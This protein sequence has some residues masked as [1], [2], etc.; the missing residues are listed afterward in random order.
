[1]IA[2]LADDEGERGRGGARPIPVARLP[3]RRGRR[4]PRSDASRGSGGP[5]RSQSAT[6][7]SS[8]P[9][10]AALATFGRLVVL[11]T[12]PLRRCPR[13][14]TARTV[15]TTDSLPG[16]LVPSGVVPVLHDDG[17]VGRGGV[18]ELQGA[19]CR[20]ELRSR[21]RCSRRSSTTEVVPSADAMSVTPVVGSIAAANGVASRRPAGAEHAEG[22]SVQPLDP[23]VE[24]DGRESSVTDRDDLRDRRRVQLLGSVRAEVGTER[25]RLRVEHLHR[26]VPLAD[27]D[28]AT[29]REERDRSRR[30]LPT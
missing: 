23:S 4:A 17:P 22:R 26:A 7:R 25:E 20:D 28:R 8:P 19:V 5:H 13:L 21:I 27:R 12:L 18:A 24:P 3:T 11:T 10:V 16:E 15:T 30:S 29:I 9:S 1:M 2:T 14:S 6:T